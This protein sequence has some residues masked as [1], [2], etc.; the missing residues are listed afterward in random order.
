[1]KTIIP[2]KRCS[3]IPSPGLEKA[4][5]TALAIVSISSSVA[6][7]STIS[8]TNHHA[9]AANAGWL[10]CL[11]S[12][13]TGVIITE[14]Y[15]S[16]YA[17]AA[18][19]GWILLGDGSPANGY[20]YSNTSATDCGVNVDGSGR[21]SGYAWSANAGW[22][23]F[24]QALGQPKLD[25]VT[26]KL[27]GHA[28]SANLGWIVLDTASSDLVTLAIACPDSDGDGMDDAWEMRYFG[29]LAAANPLS[30]ND[31]DGQTDL[32][33]FLAGSLPND[34]TSRFEV[35]AHSHSLGFLDAASITFTS[36]PNR[37]YSIESSTTLQSP[38]SGSPLGTFPPSAGPTTTKTV[39][40][41]GGA[42]RFF[43]VLAH[44]PLQP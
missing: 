27:S 33:E 19:F 26:G 13:A 17:W 8:P 11:P 5:Q 44:K 38:W 15:L 39:F 42:R 23:N 34:P 14:S 36:S 9:Y 25:F 32:S 29:N 30:D 22:I 37:I 16:G 2:A 41:G 18:N 31:A 12:S 40:H 43:R 28:W 3:R 4:M 21:L 35:T 7:Q 24:E 20:A 10:D 6:A 1:M